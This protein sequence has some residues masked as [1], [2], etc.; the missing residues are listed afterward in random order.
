[1]QQNNSQ[2]H[3]EWLTTATTIAH[4]AGEI[5]WRYYRQAETV[6]HTKGGD[7]RD[8]VT[9]ADLEVDTTIRGA[10]AAAFP[11]HAIL[12]EEAYQPGDELDDDVP[13]WLVDPIDGTNNFTHRLPW[14]AISIALH[15][16]GQSQLAVIYAPILEYTFTAV[17]GQGAFLNGKPLRVTPQT[18][19][20]Q[21]LVG[22][23]WP[24][25]PHLRELQLA[26]LTTFAEDV[27]AIRSLGCA[28]LNLAAVAA[29]WLDVY[30]NYSLWPWDTGAG[31]LLV[32]EAG[33]HITPLD[34]TP[35][36]ATSPTTLASNRH[37]HQAAAK[38]IA[39][40]LPTHQ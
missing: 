36:R 22:C 6:I 7:S 39:P 33:G 34:G 14:F 26:S 23:D 25:Q 10:L 1:M 37:L 3:D 8:L 21:A 11:D 15:H 4:Q 24:R 32:Q 19:I 28:S 13:T 9:N 20:R 35:W 16:T 38:I 27:L 29:G 12:S 18:D 5:I 2:H 31:S 17:L 30:F 40:H